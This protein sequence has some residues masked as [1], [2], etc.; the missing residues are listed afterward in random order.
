[1]TTRG[2]AWSAEHEDALRA[3]KSKCFANMWLQRRASCFYQTVYALI[4]YT[5]IATSSLASATLFS[6]NTVVVGGDTAMAIQYGLGG[7]SLL[8]ALCTAIVR[9]IQPAELQ[10]QHSHTARRYAS[11]IRSINACLQLTAD[12]RPDPVKYVEKIAGDLDTLASNQPD[13]PVAVQ[14]AFEKTYGSLDIILHGQEVTDL[15]RLRIDNHRRRAAISAPPPALDPERAR[16]DAVSSLEGIVVVAES[17]SI[18]ST[19]ESSSTPPRL[20]SVPSASQKNFK[21]MSQLIKEK[22]EHGG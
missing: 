16:S 5:V 3:W 19:V 9:Q 4:S 17:A 14:R 8:A 11:V 6:L 21:K 18:A 2:T 22:G 10:Q 20:V 1:M 7:V 15:H 12:L 13:V